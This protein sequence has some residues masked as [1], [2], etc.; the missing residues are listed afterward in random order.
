[1][2]ADGDPHRDAPLRHS[3]RAVSAR[4]L[5]QTVIL[6]LRSDSYTRLNGTASDLWDLLAEPRT[7]A[8]LAES[9]IGTHGIDETRARADV[10]T[11]I[12]PL[13]ERGLLEPA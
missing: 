5:D 2:T 10:G 6:D 7:Q 13:L 9:L 11:F 12:A 8:E 4:M 1:M 3:E